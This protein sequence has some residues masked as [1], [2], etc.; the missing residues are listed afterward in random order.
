MTPVREVD[1]ILDD[2]F[3]AVGQRVG[4]EK[5]LDTAAITWWRD[6]Y[7]RFFLHAMEKRGNSWEKDRKRVTAVGR[8]LGERALSHA[9]DSPVIDLTAALKASQDVERECQMNAV[10]EGIQPAST[11]PMPHQPD[12]QDSL[13]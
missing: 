11:A 1:Y 5:S 2:C 7:R 13:N 10:R 12:A 4:T 3:L 6:R 8:Y 9:G